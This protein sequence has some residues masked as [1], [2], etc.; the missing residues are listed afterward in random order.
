MDIIGGTSIGAFMGALF[1]E[2]RSYSQI[3]IRAK[4]WAEV[5][6]QP[7]SGRLPFKQTGTEVHVWP[8]WQRESMKQ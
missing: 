4:Q 5:S 3:R 1:A 8:V 2:E 7:P 6:R